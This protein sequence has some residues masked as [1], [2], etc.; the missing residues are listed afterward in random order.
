MV[1][2]RH[3]FILKVTNSHVE[4]TIVTW[5]SL[6]VIL[7]KGGRGEIVVSLV[8]IEHFAASSVGHRRVIDFTVLNAFIARM[9]GVSLVGDVEAQIS[10]RI[11]L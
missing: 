11:N 7:W 2:V 3:V 4:L 5:E 10:C 1:Q 9:L 6:P 8:F